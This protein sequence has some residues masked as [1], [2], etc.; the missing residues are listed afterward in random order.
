M[1]DTLLRVFVVVAGLLLPKEH[2]G[3]LEHNDDIISGMQEREGVLQRER[4]KLE[5]ELDAV[6][7]DTTLEDQPDR[8]QSH[9]SLQPSDPNLGQ[10]ITD[11]NLSVHEGQSTVMGSFSTEG[12]KETNEESEPADKNFPQG[13]EALQLEKEEPSSLSGE[14]LPT[15]QEVTTDHQDHPAGPEASREEPAEG[16]YDTP[17]TI[18]PD[19]AEAPVVEK[20]E[21]PPRND[22]KDPEV[23]ANGCEHQCSDSVEALKAKEKGKPSTDDRRADPEVNAEGFKHQGTSNS[24]EKLLQY[25]QQLDNNVRR[26]PSTKAKPTSSG[27]DYMWYLC[28]AY[29]AFSLIYFLFRFLRGSSQDQEVVDSSQLNPQTPHPITAE[30]HVPDQGTLMGFY[31]R[32][33]HVPARE[34]QRVCEFV[35]GFVDDLLAAVRETS[36][37]PADMEVE[38]FMEVGSLYESWGTGRTLTCDLWVPLAPRKPYS[39][40][41]QLLNEGGKNTSDTHG[42]RRVKLVKGGRS[43]TNG[44]PCSQTSNDN[45]MLCLLHTNDKREDEKDAVTDATNGP[46]SCDNTPCLSRVAVAKWFRSAVRKAWEQT[47]HKY[48]LELSFHSRESPGALKVRFRSGRSVHFNITPVVRFQD[49]DIYFVPYFGAKREDRAPDAQWPLSFAHYERRLLVCLGKRLPQNACHLHCLRTLSFLNKKQTELSGD[50]SLSSHHLKT[51]L[52]HL[53]LQKQPSEWGAEHFAGR[54][55]D[56][57][58]FLKTSLQKRWLGHALVGNPLVP[59]EVRFPAHLCRSKALNVLQPLL[60][61][62]HQ[63]TKTVQHFE[64]ML[65]NMPMLIREYMDV[66]TEVVPNS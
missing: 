26:K 6:A 44:C 24:G 39:F 14:Q 30:V 50:C 43:V 19:N 64:E 18:H 53:L 20:S 65:K 51:V 45:D 66:Q 31:E 60:S 17:E 27:S 3:V 16:E 13:K 8:L 41:V 42:Y 48:E 34:S 61:Q 52:L 10:I 15:Q 37:D 9:S 58:D 57:L 11:S 22:C 1:Q 32:Y 59:P 7:M 38:D 4:A 49:T 21:Q 36:N 2:P 25:E 35:E 56:A 33:V 28:N 62:G 54:L 23:N 47:S 29:S 63:Y 40:Q 5:H 46:L 12:E 55:R